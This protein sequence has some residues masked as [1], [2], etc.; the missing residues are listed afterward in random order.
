MRLT[1]LPILNQVRERLA[2]F[3]KA[4]IDELVLV[5]NT[6]HGINTVLKNFEWQQGDIL[7]HGAGI[8]L[9][10]QSDIFFNCGQPPRRTTRF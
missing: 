5:P 8:F 1:Y 2:K 9:L 7:V 4:E 10:T 3:I 6:S